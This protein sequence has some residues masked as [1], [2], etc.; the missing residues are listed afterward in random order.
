MTNLVSNLGLASFMEYP[1]LIWV[2]KFSIPVVKTKWTFSIE[3]E[4]LW[5]YRC[6]SSKDYSTFRGPIKK[7]CGHVSEYSKCSQFINVLS[8]WWMC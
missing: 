6:A 7:W 3:N 5:E 4:K 2:L 1:A 8:E